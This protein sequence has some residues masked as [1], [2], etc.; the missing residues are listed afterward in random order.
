MAIHYYT[1]SVSTSVGAPTSGTSLSFGGDLE[2]TISWDST[3]VTR[4]SQIYDA[5]QEIRLYIENSDEYNGSVALRP[6][7]WYIPLGG[8]YRDIVRTNAGGTTDSI[9][10]L[11]GDIAVESYSYYNNKN[12]LLEG[13]ELCKN[14][15]IE[16]DFPLA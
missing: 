3:T 15:L 11:G 7:G 14:A 1:A 9:L 2:V 16:G 5:V 6:A 13:L 4:K 8:T 10:E 12:A